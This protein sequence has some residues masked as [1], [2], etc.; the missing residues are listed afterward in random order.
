V[1]G[2]A[3]E[4][5]RRSLVHRLRLPIAAA[6]AAAMAVA[7][8]VGAMADCGN[9]AAA[10]L[11][12]EWQLKMTVEP[13]TGTVPAAIPKVGTAAL[14]TVS[15]S[16][17]CSASGQCTATLAP[18]GGGILPL[19]DNSVQFIWYPS[20]GLA[21]AG[22][23]YSGTTPRSGYGGPGIPPCPPPANLQHDI[24]T[25]TVVQ[26]K[27]DAA[28]GW[29]ATVVS[30]SEVSPEGWVC[31]GGAGQSTGA[32][33]LSLLAVPLGTAFP[34][35]TSL[36]CAA[37]A[38]TTAAANPDVSTFSSALATPA[39]AFGSPVHT[40]VGAAITLAVILF[41]TFPAQLFNRT[42]EENYDEIRDISLRRLRW[43]R[44]FRRDA[45]REARGLIHVGAFAAV[46]L[47]GA[48]LGSLN[49]R[50]FGLNLR[51]AATYLAVVLSILVGVAVGGAV[52]AVYRRLRRHAVEVR[53]HALPAG[54]AVA[55]I[56]V[57]I[58]RLSSFEPGYLYGVI[59]G[60]AFQGTLPQPE[61]GHTVALAA[62]AGLGIAVVAWLLWIPVGRAAAVHG[63][64]FPVVL[65]ADLLGSVFV[66]GLVG[67]VIGLMPLRFLPGGTLI[68]W[69]R[70]A[71]AATFGI[72]VFGLI[73]VEL[74]PQ[75]AS[76][77]PGSA[78]VVTAVV[79]FVF[80]GGITA[81]LRWYFSRREHD[82]EGGEE[83][84]AG[85]PTAPPAPVPETAGAPPA[86]PA[87]A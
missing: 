48:A 14:Q 23:S 79:L 86:D 32:E 27:R 68:E 5:P 28:G 87:N 9:L 18:S 70:G 65:L 21:H 7:T 82:R 56:C 25:L 49:D 50:G 63:A 11:S 52:G 26:A 83:K 17:V 31:V 77:H 43:L 64:S 4:S 40:L 41:I 80:F 74:R 35:S 71:W 33:N 55:A 19:Y 60:L 67:N 72:A 78:P 24:L 36:A 22:S 45:E 39:Q 3:V 85:A 47:V 6:A 2:E 54:L 44:R 61:Q 42:F 73:E 1:K 81:G 69:N 84:P 20:T 12:G 51:S 37:P 57:L 76:A 15:L 16:T 10:T 34:P 53:L 29:Q 38:R 66:G 46:V 58:S 8:A 30:G 62:I 13:P 59:A 75:S